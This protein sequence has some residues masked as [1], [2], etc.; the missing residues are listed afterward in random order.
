MSRFFANSVAALAAIL[1]ASASFT[2][3][4]NVPDTPAFASSDSAAAMPTLA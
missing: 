3:I 2:A 1:I 4:V